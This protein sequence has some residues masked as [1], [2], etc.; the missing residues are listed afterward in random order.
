MNKYT[1]KCGS[2]GFVHFLILHK[3]WSSR[4]VFWAKNKMDR[5]FDISNENV[6]D[7]F[8][9]ELIWPVLKHTFLF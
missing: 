4:I 7:M 2:K 6:I 5:F 8:R 1:K 9:L 3:M